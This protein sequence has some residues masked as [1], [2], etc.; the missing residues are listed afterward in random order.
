MKILGMSILMQKILSL[1]ILRRTLS[2][3]LALDSWIGK[4]VPALEQVRDIIRALQTFTAELFAEI[5]SN[6]NIRAFTILEKWFIL[7][8]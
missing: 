2:L 1:R 5:N 6:V 8:A 4:Q 7:D 3:R